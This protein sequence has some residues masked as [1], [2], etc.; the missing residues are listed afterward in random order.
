MLAR[1]GYEP[2][3]FVPVPEISEEDL[4]ALLARRQVIG[5]AQGIVM[6]RYNLTS[7]TA[8]ALLSRLSQE[9]NLKL[10]DL[11][12]HVVRTRQLPHSRGYKMLLDSAEQDEEPT[13]SA[14]T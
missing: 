13:P 8:H 4:Q 14:E 7:E 9:N 12:V 10:H 6:E 11:A 3:H 1:W 2:S 5:E